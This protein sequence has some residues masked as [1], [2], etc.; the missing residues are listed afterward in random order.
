MYRQR[1]P[2]TASKFFDSVGDGIFYAAVVCLICSFIGGAIFWIVIVFT[3]ASAE[4][5]KAFANM[6]NSYGTG[7]PDLSSEGKAN[8]QEYAQRLV[9]IYEDTP[10]GYEYLSFSDEKWEQIQL[11]AATGKPAHLNTDTKDF[12]SVFDGWFKYAW[13]LGFVTIL[14]IGALIARSNYGAY[15]GYPVRIADLPWQSRLWPWTTT[16]VL[17]PV[18]WLAMAISAALLP[19]TPL[20]PEEEEQPPNPEF[21]TGDF[22]HGFRTRTVEVPE[23][24]AKRKATRTYPSSPVAARDRYVAIRTS[25]AAE[26]RE[27]ALTEAKKDLSRHEDMAK[28]YGIALRETQATINQL[29]ATR[30]RL[31]EAISTDAHVGTQIAGEEFDRIAQLPGV[32]STQAVNDHVRLIVRAQRLYKEV[33]YDLGDWR[34]EIGASTSEID[35]LEIRSGVR[36]SWDDGEPVY[37]LDEDSF[38]FGE[39]EDIINEHLQKGQYLEALAITVECLNGVNKEDRKSIPD[40]FRKVKT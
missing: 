14:G 6:L 19:W 33:L 24:L 2:T 3:N 35:A 29:R 7:A 28:T 21:N 4:D 15:Q 39:R 30:K 37:R 16:L 40:A 17:G 32:I 23:I 26:H 20:T 22:N 9:D 34:I 36:N 8:R 12:M 11:V 27:G 10:D 38:C 13:G 5:N 25:A 1:R 18:F 31:E